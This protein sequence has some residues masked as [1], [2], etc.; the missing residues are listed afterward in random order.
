M[1][2]KNI[3]PKKFNKSVI[4]ITKRIESFFNFF[5]NNFFNKKK[6]NL[7]NID[8][9]IILALAIIFISISSYFLL[10][11]FYDQNKIK[12]QIENLLLDEYN[13]EV[14]LDQSLKYGVFPR[15]HFY[16]KNVIINYKSKEIAKAESAKIS[17]ITKNLFS[18]KNIKIKK[19][20]FRETDFRLDFSN[21]NFFINL[22]NNIDGE[23]KV[24]F[25]NSKLFYLD[26]N[27]DVIF[28][29]N[30]KKLDYLFDD[31]LYKKLNSKLNIF[32]IP[33]NL[34]VRYNSLDKNFFIETNSHPLRLNIKNNSNYDSEKLKGQLDFTLVNKDK[35]ISYIYKN[36]T[37]NFNTEDDKIKGNI[38]IKPFFITTNLKIFQ[39]DLKEIFKENSV[40]V[41]FL[42]S[43]ALNNKN[44]NGEI[45]FNTNNLKRINFLKEIVFSI[46]LEEGQVS[47]KNLNANF[48]ESVVINLD[49]T[50]LIVDDNQ[51]KFSGFID[52]DF[53]NIK[54]FFEH[55]QINIKDRKYIKRISLAFLFHLDEKFIEI[56]N[57]EVDGN[58]NDNLNDF[59][60]DF[61]LKKEN[62]FNNI[63]FRNSVK[64][65]FKIISLD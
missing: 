59:L 47:I 36:N 55:Y 10:P 30:I 23:E 62:V 65:F 48:K 57:F 44:L 54:K 40:L 5:A 56:D 6:R 41:N 3:F 35:K 45:K 31:D 50:Q 38:N 11:S 17:I 29:S 53:I 49:N 13:L 16:S 33:I 42:K 28:I 46:I 37:L 15:P 61:N 4:S 2:K 20:I 21:F 27:D 7:K 19:I 64:D 51:L 60:N 9:R 43:E 24:N 52:L 58:I 22:L 25:I 18:I 26:Q 14:K 8:N 32:N 34:S 12:N 39:I 1:Q 63:I